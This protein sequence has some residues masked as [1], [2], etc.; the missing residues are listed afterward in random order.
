MSPWKVKGLSVHIWVYPVAPSSKRLKT[1]KILRHAWNGSAA[2][3]GTMIDFCSETHLNVEL[4]QKPPSRSIR[5]RLPKDQ[6]LVEWAFQHPEV[7]EKL[8]DPAMVRCSA[9]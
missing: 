5:A 9:S 1:L 6:R 3:K 8:D 2:K 4:S 7:F